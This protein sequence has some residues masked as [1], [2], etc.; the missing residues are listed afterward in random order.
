FRLFDLT[1][2]NNYSYNRYNYRAN[3]D[4][5]VTNTTKLSIT[6]GG[7]SEVRNEPI[8]DEP[9]FSIW[10]NIYFAQPYRGIGIVDGK[11]IQSH[12]IYIPG[13]TRDALNGYYGRGFQNTL[14]NPLNLDLALTQK[15]DALTEGL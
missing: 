5:E 6:S 9:Q 12:P 8:S 1:D 2:N 14:T 3:L 7:R 13:E 15:L 10:R 11:H 4:I